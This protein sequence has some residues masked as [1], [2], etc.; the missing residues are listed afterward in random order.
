[1]LLGVIAPNIGLSFTEDIGLWGRITNFLLPLGVIWLLTSITPKIGATVLVCIPLYAF[2][3]FQLVLLSLHGK[4][5]IAVDMFLNLVTTNT[6]EA[7]ELLGNIIPALICIAVYFIPLIG[8]GIYAFCHRI[9]LPPSFLRRSKRIALS[10][11]GG[12]LVA[13]AGSYVFNP[14]YT[15]ADDLYPVNIA[16]NIFLAG[17]RSARSL[18]QHTTSAGYKYYPLTTHHPDQKEI[19][20]LVIGETSRAANWQLAG[21][22]R[23]TTPRLSGEPGLIFFNNALSESNTTHKSVPMLLSPVSAETFDSE[24]H[25]VKSMISGFK[26]AGFHTA[27]L[28][29]QLPNHSYIDYF[30]Y[31]ADTTLFVRQHMPYLMRFNDRLLLPALH[32]VLSQDHEKLLIVLH[33]Y[34]SHFNYLDRYNEDEAVFKPDRYENAC[35]SHRK[36]LVNAYDNTILA[37]DHFLSDVIKEVQDKDCVSAVIFTSDH[38]EDI[39]DDGGSFLH[40]SP[41]PSFHQLH[42]PF[43]IWLSPGYDEAY[44]DIRRIL[45]SH[46]DAPLSTSRAF[47]P[48]AM[49]IAGIK[50]DKINETDA[51]SSSTYSPRRRI[52]LNDHNEAVLLSDILP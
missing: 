36:E 21:Y 2:G 11:T 41:T 38:G 22:S 52:Y 1:M 4:G 48:T 50:S 40:A 26:E 20:V 30:G 3:A 17:Q 19:Y 43:F 44:P 8:G 14:S 6:R 24:I 15:V 51:I 46:T 29:N 7:S 32:D 9:M 49:N 18:H 25:R 28:S 35:Q 33:S 5:V 31:E 37:T 10:I 42:V 47:T 13:L 39:Y 27:F 34:G 16:Y 23:R 45:K 12:G